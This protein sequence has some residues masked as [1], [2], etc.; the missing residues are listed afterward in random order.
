MQDIIIRYTRIPLGCRTVFYCLVQNYNKNDRMTADLLTAGQYSTGRCC[1]TFSDLNINI[2]GIKQ[3]LKNRYVLTNDGS[4]SDLIYS[5]VSNSFR[6]MP[7]S[8]TY[9]IPANVEKFAHGTSF[10]VALDCM[11]LTQIQ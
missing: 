10:T 6:V 2:K 5:T 7:K 9:S 1:T 11:N 8:S 4:I 3:I